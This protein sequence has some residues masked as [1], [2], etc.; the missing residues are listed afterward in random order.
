MSPQSDTRVRLEDDPLR[1]G[2][3]VGACSVVDQRRRRW[4]SIEP[5]LAGHLV[6]VGPHCHHIYVTKQGSVTKDIV[7]AWINPLLYFQ[8]LPGK[9]L[10]IS[11]IVG[12]P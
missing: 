7:L 3:L 9:R 2:C 8:N 5:T 4:A 10:T 12:K 1:Q 11:S 6:F